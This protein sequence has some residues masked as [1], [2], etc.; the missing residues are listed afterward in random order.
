M[1]G[2]SFLSR[3]SGTGA[4]AGVGDDTGAT[5][6]DGEESKG[7]APSTPSAESGDRGDITVA[8]A[9]AESVGGPAAGVAVRRT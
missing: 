6:G 3:G 5:G 8:A 4:E 2:S 1:N 7:T 9:I